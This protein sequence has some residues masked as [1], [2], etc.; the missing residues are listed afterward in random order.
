ML[1]IHKDVATS[2]GNA[3]TVPGLEIDARRHVVCV[4]DESTAEY[5]ICI[6]SLKDEKQ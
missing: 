5:L 1:I 3:G 6:S 2:S 4:E